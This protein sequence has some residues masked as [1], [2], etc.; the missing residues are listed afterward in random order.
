MINIIAILLWLLA[1]TPPA[2]SARWDS[3][4]SATIAWSTPGR[5]CLSVTH[6][7]G[8]RVFIGCYE[9]A[10]VVTLG[11]PQTDGAYRPMSGD[12]YCMAG[13][14]CAPLIGRAQ[15]LAAVRR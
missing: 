15:Y 3:A 10:A 11:G 7:T 14:G 1:P 6:A 8:Q 13:V 12:V 4:T 9:G 2:F 5:A